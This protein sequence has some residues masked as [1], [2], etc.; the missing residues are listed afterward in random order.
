MSDFKKNADLIGWVVKLESQVES[1]EWG[2]KNE[3]RGGSTET[4]NKMSEDIGRNGEFRYLR[5]G[6]S[7]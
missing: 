1:L 2:D 4:E 7:Y 3:H 5:I 6:S